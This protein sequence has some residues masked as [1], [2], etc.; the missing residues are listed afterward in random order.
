MVEFLF[1][2]LECSTHRRRNSFVGGSWLMFLVPYFW[3]RAF[4]D[5]LPVFW[6]ICLEALSCHVCLSEI[7]GLFGAVMDHHQCSG[8]HV[9]VLW[10]GKLVCQRFR[11]FVWSSCVPLPIFWMICSEAL[12]WHICFL[13]FSMVCLELLWPT[14]QCSGT[15]VQAFGLWSLFVTDIDGLFGAV[16]AQYQSFG[17]DVQKL[18]A[19]TFC[20][21]EISMVCLELMWP[22]TS[23]LGHMSRSFELTHLFLRDSDGLFGA[24]VFWSALQ[25]SAVLF[26]V[27]EWSVRVRV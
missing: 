27:L 25:C 1:E 17:W 18:R 6:M 13:Q 15:H 5:P 20:L 23:L 9:Q 14:F 24:S 12:G 7:D 21:S 19:V 10:T 4:I 11:W 3:L 16:V 8:T 2:S 22:T 26:G